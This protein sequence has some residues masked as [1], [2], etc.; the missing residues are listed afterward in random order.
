MPDIRIIKGI[1]IQPDERTALKLAGY[2]EGTPSWHDGVALFQELQPLLRRVM[3]PKASLGFAADGREPLGAALVLTLGSAVGKQLERFTADHDFSKDLLFSTMA[4]SCL[5]ALEKQVMAQVRQICQQKEIGIARRHESGVDAPLETLSEAVEMTAAKRTLQVTLTK[6]FVLLPEKTMVIL[7]DLTKDS[8]VF[9]VDHSCSSC[10]K[11]DCALREEDTPAIEMDCPADVAV[12]DFIQ[13]QGLPL[14]APCG[15]KGVCGKCKVRILSGT[16]PET[17]EDKEFFT[18]TELADGWRLACQAVTTAEVTLEIPPH[19]ESSFAALGMTE[20]QQD[21][22]KI[23]LDHQTGI[24]IDIGS[25]TLAAS[26]VD[27][28]TKEVIHTETTVNQQRRFGADVISRIQAANS[29]HAKALHASIC[30]DVASL[31]VRLAMAYPA[32][33]RT[34][35]HLVIAGNTTMEH[36]FMGYS[37]EGLGSWPFHPITLGGETVLASKAMGDVGVP[38]L[39]KQSV[40]L[41]PGISTFVGA[42]IT[43]GIWKCQ[44]TKTDDLSLLLDLGTNGEM[45]IGNA[46]G[47][48]V[49]STAAGPALEGGNLSCGTGSVSGAISGVSIRHGRAVTKTIDNA[50]PVGICGTG[51]IECL[52]A[53]VEQGL[54]DHNG[55]LQEPYFSNG[56]YLGETTDGKDIRLTQQDIR[57]IQMAKGAIRA[58]LETL[59]ATYGATYDDI[60]QVYL[61]GGFGYYLN[62][63]KAALMGLLPKE[64]APRTKAVGNT[65][66]AG[67]VGA[68]IEPEALAEM[69]Q[70]QQEAKEIVLGNTPKFQ[71]LYIQ[72]MGF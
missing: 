40:T 33:P 63:T 15:G 20:E 50:A 72:Y 46:N 68:L 71:E 8:T 29:G 39:T 4:D 18:P 60:Q 55:K 11:T 2:K 59:M 1:Q 37:C 28:T 54:V 31:C 51:V 34:Y 44:M 47:L 6:D 35:S 7:F 9:H 49:A 36:L 57:E 52:A 32:V 17:R 53:L 23:P 65:S 43:A 21:R 10:S 27:L 61:A 70:I 67:A 16:L 69:K 22:K 14:A 41:L 13:D 19:D 12:L 66:L 24:A 3:Q 56:F 64:L 30:E 25:T 42:D 62:P 38:W 26:L 5:F 45:A 48:L 58:G